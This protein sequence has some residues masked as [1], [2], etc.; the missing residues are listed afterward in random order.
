M[1]N[2]DFRK[3]RINENV[4]QMQ[5]QFGNCATLIVG[6]KRVV[7]FDTMI[8][9]GDLRRCVEEITALPLTIINSHGHSEYR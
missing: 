8:G 2:D 1:M 9:I 5:D 7:L 6:T 4:I 3:T